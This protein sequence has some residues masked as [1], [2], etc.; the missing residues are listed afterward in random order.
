MRILLLNPNMT[1]SVTATMAE[2]GRRVAASGT[3]LVPV[4]APRG[5]PYIASRS[6]AQIGGVVAL[7]MLAAQAGEIDA[8][9]IAAFGDPGLLAARELFN[10]PV[11]GVAEA[12]LLTARLVGRS[13]ALL[14]FSARFAAWYAE[15]VEANG[16]AAQCTG[17]HALGLTDAEFEA[18]LAV[19]EQRLLGLV[20]AMVG[21]AGPD[22]LICAGAPLAGLANRVADRLPVPVIDPVAAAV[23][24]AEAL[25]ALGLR[26]PAAGA[27]RRPEGKDSLGLDATLAAYLKGRS[28]D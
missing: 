22:S 11:V 18:D 12:A 16:M 17:I 25:V 9:I 23:K 5:L 8:A 27:F 6:E 19:K 1:Q 2:A 7:E 20:D 13:F 3:E 24:Q 10:F 26:P 15:C 21:D 4:T 14:T 28:S